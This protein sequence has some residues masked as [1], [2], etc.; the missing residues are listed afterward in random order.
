LFEAAQAGLPIIA[1][2]WS[3]H[4]DFLTMP[5]KGKNKFIPMKIDYDLRHVQKEAVWP[6]V[7]Q[8]DSMWCFPK[9]GS[10]KMKLRSM[11]EN[12]GAMQKK[13]TQ[14]A[15]HLRENWPDEE[16]VWESIVETFYSKKEREE[17]E[18]E[19]NSLL[20]DLL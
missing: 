1:P 7:I 2:A 9:E 19:I 3:G 4:V 6:K 11:M 14:L 20:E 15:E 18:Q 8:E 10:F 5:V 12:H 13:A 17:L 16:A